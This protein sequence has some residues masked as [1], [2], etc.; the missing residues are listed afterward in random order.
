MG[1]REEYAPPFTPRLLECLTGF[2]RDGQSIQRARTSEQADG[3]AQEPAQSPKAPPDEGASGGWIQIGQ[4][5]GDIRECPT[6]LAPRGGMRKL[7][8]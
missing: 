8:E 3:L 2:G 4:S 1:G 5:S 6:T 7:P